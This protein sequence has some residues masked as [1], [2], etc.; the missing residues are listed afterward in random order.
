MVISPDQP[1]LSFQMTLL[2]STPTYNS[3]EQMWEFVSEFAVRDYSGTYYVKLI[4]CT[5]TQ[6]R[7]HEGRPASCFVFVT[8]QTSDHLRFVQH[9][10]SYFERL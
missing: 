6:V 2:R 1:N 10:Q 7:K 3:P 5:V 9:F 4:P 8:V